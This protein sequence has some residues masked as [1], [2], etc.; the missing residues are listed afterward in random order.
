MERVIEPE[1]LDIMPA[2]QTQAIESR[3]DLRRLNW[4]MNHSGIVIRALRHLPRPNR[5]LDLGAGDGTFTLRV[6]EAMGW[7]GAEVILLDRLAPVPFA[8]REAFEK[9]DCTVTILQCEAAA[10]LHD[11]GAVDLVLT[12]LFL[13]HFERTALQNLLITA[14]AH[15]GVFVA[16][17]PRR[18]SLSLWSSR[19]VGLIGCNAVTRHD[20]VASVRAGFVA[21]EIS[22][23]WPNKSG[24]HLTEREA[25]LFSHLFVARRQ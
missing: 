16:C 3:R 11:A 14:A 4:L 25:G 12:N 21:D 10:G 9:L 22:N 6:A 17:E 8:V 23:L 19:A 13:H 7:R 1:W 20:A 18:C 24:W 5:V 15:C 2:D